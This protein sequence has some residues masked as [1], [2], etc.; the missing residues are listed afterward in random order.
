MV[1]DENMIADECVGAPSEFNADECVGAP[2]GWYSRGYLPHFDS[3]FV[4]QTVTYRLADSLPNDVAR[5]LSAEY[6]NGWKSPEYRKR[7]EDYVDAGDGA[8][9]LRRPEIAQVVVDRWRHFDG[10]QYC[11]HAWVIM[12]NHVHLIVQTLAGFDLGSAIQGW[13]TFSARKI[14]QVLRRRG[15]VWQREY[16]DRF[17]RNEQHYQ[18]AMAYVREN[19]VRAGLVSRAEDW[20]WLAAPTPSSPTEELQTPARAPAL[21]GLK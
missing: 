10:V 17:I 16:W 6:P 11:L 8:C 3:S 18:R 20:P 13:K 1:G 5:R 12:P 19:P 4:I 9:W 14:N 2:R 21:P 7:I 15:A